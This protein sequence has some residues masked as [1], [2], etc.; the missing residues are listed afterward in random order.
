MTN[1]I[2][3]DTKQTES[4]INHIDKTE[5]IP[6]ESTISPTTNNLPNTLSATTTKTEKTETILTTVEQIMN[7]TFI[8]TTFNKISTN[9]DEILSTIKKSPTTILE[10]IIK[11]S[12]KIKYE[13]TYVVIL[14]F[15]QFK[16]FTKYF[17]FYIYLTPT[18]NTLYTKQ[19]L[20]PMTISYYRNIRRLLKETQANCTLELIESGSKYK[21][22]CHVDEETANIKEVKAELDFDFVTQ[23][24]VTL[25]GVTPLAKMYMNNMLTMVYR[26]EYDDLIDNSF[27]YI[28]DNSTLYKYNNLFFNISGEI[29]DPQ[30]KLN[31]KNLI[32]MINLENDEKPKTEVQCNI[33]NF[34]RNNYILHCEANETFDGELQS[35]ISFIDDNDILLINFGDIKESLINIKVTQN[36]NRMYYSKNNGNGLKA[37]TIAGIAIA[38]AAA[39]AFAIFLAFYLRRK[40][41]KIIDDS[42]STFKELKVDS[43]KY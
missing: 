21:Y 2:N 31:N 17:T 13:E 26:N 9:F 36:Y 15:S 27:I 20:F 22:Y 18:R 5:N 23:Y 42:E 7:T 3:E 33:S 39:T 19:I 29:N 4:I 24:N 11:T 25:S 16:L 10:T 41:K 37:G 12:E 14:G 30:P 8:A 35:A 32:L 1:Q 28:M 34:T 38:I 40:N 43:L 6:K